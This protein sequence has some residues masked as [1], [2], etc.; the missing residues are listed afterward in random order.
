MSLEVDDP[1]AY[2]ESSGLTDKSSIAMHIAS[3]GKGLTCHITH[4]VIVKHCFPSL[5]AGHILCM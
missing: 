5:V 4:L 3:Y 2:R 1:V